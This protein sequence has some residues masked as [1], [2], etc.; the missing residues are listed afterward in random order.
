MYPINPLVEAFKRVEKR[1]RMEAMK[2]KAELEKVIK[3]MAT[4]M[5]IVRKIKRTIVPA[6]KKG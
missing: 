4:Q 6:I 3:K 2:E 1:R 5:K